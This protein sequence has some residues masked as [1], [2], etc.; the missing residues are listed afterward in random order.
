MSLVQTYIESILLNLDNVLSLLF[1][2]LW[3]MLYYSHK[4]EVIV[5]IVDPIYQ[6]L[7]SGWIWHKVNF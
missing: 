7:H 3:L 6:P 2:F 1:I 5:V 4:M